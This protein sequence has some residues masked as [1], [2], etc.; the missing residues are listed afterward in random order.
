MF[1]DSHFFTS[2]SIDRMNMLA[3]EFPDSKHNSQLL[4]SASKR[5][6]LVALVVSI[7]LVVSH[8]AALDPASLNLFVEVEAMV[9]VLLFP[10]SVDYRTKLVQAMGREAVGSF[11]ATN[12]S[13]IT[14]FI[15]ASDG[16][17]A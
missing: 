2:T 11:L 15:H 12:R 16:I 10:P 13:S 14:P 6:R 5:P 9:P 4:K 3:N 17:K 7:H 1:P 8:L